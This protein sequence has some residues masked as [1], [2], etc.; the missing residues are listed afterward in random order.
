MTAGQRRRR[1]VVGFCAVIDVVI[2][3]TCIGHFAMNPTSVRGVEATTAPAGALYGLIVAI[4]YMAPSTIG[5]LQGRRL[6]RELAESR[7]RFDAKRGPE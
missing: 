2:L 6:R 3:V 1:R 7:A 5:L 4:V